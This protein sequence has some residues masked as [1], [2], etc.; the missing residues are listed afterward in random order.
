MHNLLR[1]ILRK[2]EPTPQDLDKLRSLL[3]DL[4]LQDGVSDGEAGNE[5]EEEEEAAAAENGADGEEA[6]ERDDSED[7]DSSIDEDDFDWDEEIDGPVFLSDDEEPEEEKIVDLHADDPWNAI[8]VLGLRVYSMCKNLTIETIE[9][10][11]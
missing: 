9:G 1:K 5:E 4:K 11:N 2:G 10:G 7:T 3:G 8:C 6:E